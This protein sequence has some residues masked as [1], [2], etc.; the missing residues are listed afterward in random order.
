[1]P[2]CAPLVLFNMPKLCDLEACRIARYR[3][4]KGIIFGVTGKTDPEKIN[5]FISQGANHVFS[6]PLDLEKLRYSINQLGN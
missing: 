5:N 4:Y 2:N 3:G 1:M 6:K